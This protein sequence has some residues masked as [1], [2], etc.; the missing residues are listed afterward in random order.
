MSH[1]FDA[2]GQA[3]EQI[4]GLAGNP[5]L[6]LFAA[7][8]VKMLIRAAWYSTLPDRTFHAIFPKT[9][10]SHRILFSALLDG[11]VEKARATND[12]LVQ[13]VARLFRASAAG[14]RR[15]RRTG[16]TERAYLLHPPSRPT[17]KAESV[18]RELSEAI[19]DMGWQE[20]AILGNESELM[21]RFGVGRPVL[22]EAI[23]SLERLGAA[24]ME[25]GRGSGLKIISPNPAA[26]V[27][28][29]RRFLDREGL[30]WRD[31]RELLE[32]LDAVVPVRG[33]HGAGDGGAVQLF[34]AILTA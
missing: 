16:S 2:I 4:T 25:R 26:A 5:A 9:T 32:L 18:S 30:R 3:W 19:A 22:R 31:R 8:L 1:K 21:A 34:R 27:E 29:G 17:K 24:V 23:R 33:S 10:A 7:T 13:R 15:P 6:S 11:D 14:G 12:E 20:G 28:A